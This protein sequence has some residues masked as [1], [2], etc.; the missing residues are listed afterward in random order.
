MAPL[1]PLSKCKVGVRL[2]PVRLCQGV[3]EGP[4]ACYLKKE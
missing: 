2:L 4:M 1:E 3:P